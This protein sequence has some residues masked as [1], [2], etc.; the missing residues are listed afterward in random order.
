MA[1]KFKT[2]QE[3]FW[4]G[5]F[6]ADYIGRNNSPQLLAS[7]LNFFSKALKQAGFV[8]SCLEFGANIG[9]NLKALQLL[10]PDIHLQAVEINRDAATQVKN[11]IGEN[12]VYEG[13]I[14]EYPVVE[15]VEL[16][17]IKGVLIHINPDMLDNVYE[18]LYQSSNRLILICEYYNPI[19]VVIPYR[20]HADR[21]FK[22]D[23][24]G[25]MLDKYTDLKLVDYGFSYH[26]D[27]AFPG[28]DGTWFLLQKA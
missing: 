1:E 4:A 19:P 26:R 3:E 24:A 17:L 18:K 15:K 14:F 7:K 22:R 27:P 6:G 9:M 2:P 23:F 5:E 8:T 13:S 16:T 21:L 25:E 20:G 12:N 10:Y 11:L 28:D